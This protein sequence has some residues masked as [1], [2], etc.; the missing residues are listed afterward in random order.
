MLTRKLGP[1]LAAGCTAVCK[2]AEDTPLCALA[3]VKLATE[4]GIPAGVIN[5]LPASRSRGIEAVDVWL[6]DFRVRKISFTGSTAVGKYLAERSAK[7]LKRVSLELG[8]NAPFIV[9]DDA[10]IGKA[11]AG[12][13]ASKFRNTGQTCVCANRIFEQD[14]IYDA[15]AERLATVVRAMTMGAASDESSATLGPLI[16]DKAVKK[17]QQYILDATSKGAKVLVGGKRDLQGANFFQATVLTDATMDMRLAN[18]ETFGPVAALFR[19]STEQE[20]I[21]LANSNL[22]GLAAY[23]YTNDL[24]R[25]W[26]VAGALQVGMV[27][28]NEGAISTE[29]APFG[30]VKESGYRREGSLYGIDE[31]LNIKYLCIGGFCNPLVSKASGVRSCVLRSLQ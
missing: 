26:R 11:I 20:V 1:A 8:G 3:L 27:G 9:F 5:V 28:I 2:P 31:Y 4:A 13:I 29:V 16:N 22:A 21:A 15:F 10:D 23:F 24:A 18:E 6:D 7:T 12:L 14:G 17:V 25:I 19:F 30:G